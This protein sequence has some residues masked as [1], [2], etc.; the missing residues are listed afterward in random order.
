MLVYERSFRLQQVQ[1]D[2]VDLYIEETAIRCQKL[3]CLAGGALLNAMARAALMGVRHR[4]FARFAHALHSSTLSNTSRAPVCEAYL[5]GVR[6]HGRLDNE[7]ESEFRPS[8]RCSIDD[9]VFVRR[10]PLLP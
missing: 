2:V 8:A 5:W 9:I 4:R 7:L 3:M 6:S 1:T 10:A